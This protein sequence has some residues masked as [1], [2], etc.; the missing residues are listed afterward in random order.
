MDCALR[1]HQYADLAGRHVEQPAGLDDFETLVHESRGID[2]DAL[3]HLPC[4]MIE[5]LLDGDVAEIF[6]RSIQ[7]RTAQGGKPDPL[8]L[9]AASAAHALV[10]GIVL[11]VNRQQRLALPAGFGGDQL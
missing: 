1:M 11:A 3:A 2:G 4:R 9:V 5:S 6:Q 7:E 10:N 8:Y